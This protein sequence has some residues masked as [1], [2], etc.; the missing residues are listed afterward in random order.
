MTTT[1]ERI[2]SDSTS[3]QDYLVPVKNLLVDSGIHNEVAE[4][5]PAILFNTNSEKTVL[6]SDTLYLKIHDN[7]VTQI[8]QKFNIPSQY[9]SKLKNGSDWEKSLFAK[10]LSDHFD[11]STRQN[12]KVLVRINNGVLKAFLSDRFERYN[13]ASVLATFAQKMAENGFKIAQSYYDGISYFVEFAD[14]EHPVM[15]NGQAHWFGVQYRNSDFGQS[16]LDIKLMLVKQICT[17]GVVMNTV[18]RQVHKGK[19]LGFDANQF[20]LSKETF[21]LEG[22]LKVSIINDIIPQIVSQEARNNLV[23]AF[24]KV[25]KLDIPVDTII[26]Q[27]PNV[28]TKSDIESIQ[29]IL[30]ANTEESGVRD[31]GNVLRVANAISYLANGLDEEK[32]MSK[33]KYKDI[34]GQV[35]MKYVTLN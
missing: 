28:V 10:T 29:K 31:C 13:S 23:D 34:A 30:M 14:K 22:Q 16:A 17:N 2:I 26:K 27:L 12:D 11:F 9:L 33:A 6:S 1:L 35:I 3:I 15:I 4:K 25:D 20:Q 32:A 7:A 18:M 8:G 5:V 24:L 21:E 19:T